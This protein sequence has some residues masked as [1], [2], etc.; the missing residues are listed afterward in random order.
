MKKQMTEVKQLRMGKETLLP[1][2][3]R[4]MNQVAAGVSVTDFAHAAP[5]EVYHI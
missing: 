4:P 2:R 5:S 1:L 3:S